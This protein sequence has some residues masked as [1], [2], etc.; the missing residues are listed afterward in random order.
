MK[1][2]LISSA[3]ALLFVASGACAPPPPSAQPDGG[4]TVPSSQCSTVCAA[5]VRECGAPPMGDPCAQTCAAL[6]TP[7]QVACLA[8]ST[9]EQ[10]ASEFERGRVPCAQ[11]GAPDA[12][13]GAC[14]PNAAPTCEGDTVVRCETIAGRPTRSTQACASGERCENARCVSTAMCLPLGS[15]G[16][17]STP[18]SC[19]AGA[20]CFATG[21]A[22]ERVLTCC[23]QQGNRC[24]NNTDCCGYDASARFTNRCVGGACMLSL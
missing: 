9:C 22:D 18:G 20:V 17:T 16:C 4:T 11:S 14:D 7:A 2:N 6:T 15:T 21:P 10:L 3:I 8:S 24:S 13:T 12:G 5:R 23:I 1:L 19:C